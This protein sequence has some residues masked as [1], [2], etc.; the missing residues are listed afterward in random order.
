MP[1]LRSA[2]ALAAALLLAAFQDGAPSGR[3]CPDPARPCPGFR[4]H[5]LSFV[6]PRGG[7]ARAESRSLPFYAVILRSGPRCTVPERE[8]RGAQALFPRAKV[9]AHR[10]ECDGDVENAV[11]YTG[12]DARYG[13]LA[14]YAGETR[15]GADSALARVRATGRFPGANLRRVQAVRVHP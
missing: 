3:P 14:L 12:V 5:D 13:F 10:F 15:A 8:R 6:L 11:T 9:F 7:P 2:A 4:P 1:M